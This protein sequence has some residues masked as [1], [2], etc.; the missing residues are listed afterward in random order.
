M[1]VNQ[2][3]ESS[4]H[5]GEKKTENRRGFHQDIIRFCRSCDVCQRT[6]KRGSVKNLP[7]GS[8]SLISMPFKRVV[9]DIVGPIA[10]P[11]DARDR[12][13][14]TLVDY[15]IRY[16]EAVPRR[17]LLRPYLMLYSTCTVEWEFLKKYPPIRELSSCLS[18]CRKYL[19]YS[20]LRV[21]QVCLVNLFATV[22]LRDAME[23]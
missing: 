5:L 17:L 15:S 14:L 21:L 8:M 10:P 4:G 18:A 9:V 1:S 13:I 6:V 3:S 22:W 16:P 2:E 19:D 12:Y 7:L 20:V 11:S 23:P